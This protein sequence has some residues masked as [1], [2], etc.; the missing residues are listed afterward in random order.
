VEKKDL[1]VIRV[2]TSAGGVYREHPP[3]S[4]T[5]SV[6]YHLRYYPG[7]VILRMPYSEGRAPRGRP[8]LQRF[9]AEFEQDEPGE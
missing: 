2:P 1:R 8:D 6:R 4:A 3:V 9:L 5:P 7:T